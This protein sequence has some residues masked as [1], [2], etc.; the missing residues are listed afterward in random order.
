V[1]D[2]HSH[3]LPGIDDGSRS[4][5]QS[6]DTLRRF[7]E[8]GITDVALTPHLRAGEIPTRGEEMIEKRG[9]LLAELRHHVHPGI[10]LHL[11]FE[12][13]LDAPLGPYPLRDRRFSV[14]GSRYYLVEFPMSIGGAP[15]TAAIG[16]IVQ[17]G[18]VPLVAH[19]ERYH[20]CT[21]RDFRSW[22]SLGAVLQVDATS[23]TRPTIRGDMGRKLIQEGLCHVLAADNHGD[24]RLLL[25]GRRYL[26]ERAGKET[27][28]WLTTENPKAVL[29]DRDMAAVAPVKLKMRLGERVRGWVRDVRG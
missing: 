3:L 16:Q 25:T 15:A 29:E 24:R 19:P 17:A 23:I 7:V 6:V 21:L 9:L 20:A 18:A 12:I 10:G 26:E 14:A 4:V 2:L 27:A 13:M 22:V 8:A 1:I 28:H 11:G 5:Q